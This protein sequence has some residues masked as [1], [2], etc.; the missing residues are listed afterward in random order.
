MP[1]KSHSSLLLVGTRKGAFVF[2]SSDGRRSWKVSGPHFRGKEI[3]HLAYDRRNN[4][5]LASVNDEQWGPSVARSFDLGKTWKIS[6]APKFPKNSKR[7]AVK[8]VWHIRPG[9]ESEPD[10][11]YCGVEP[12]TLFRSEDRGESWAVNSAMF[13]HETRPK[14]QPG[15]GGLCLHSILIEENDPRNLHVGISAVGTMNSTDGGE[16]WKFQNK[17]VLADFHPDKYPEYGQCVHK[18][19]RHNSRPEVLFQQNHCGI[20]RSDDNGNDWKDI[21]NNLP[22]RFGFPIA[23]DANDP[24]R[25][26]VAP[27]EEAYS[28]ISPEGKFSVWVTENSG[29][30]WQSLGRGFP[31][32]A[33]FTVLRDAM[34]SD[35][36]DPCGLYVGTTTGHLYASR[37]QGNAWIKVTD[38]L[39]PIA[40]VSA[41]TTN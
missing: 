15:F 20:Y 23:I 16:S 28:R 33:Y 7:E 25:V 24:K 30:E 1:K 5:L 17:N 37:N 32:P 39:P 29:K 27:L 21:R 3:Y 22:S 10:V 14:W 8:R 31:K 36:E 38:T 19:A 12:A 26:Y 40:S 11:I 9:T 13:T 6:S 41:S 35:L 34:T 2:S 18:L 4:L